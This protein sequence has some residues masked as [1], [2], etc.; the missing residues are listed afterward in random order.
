M[1]P[2]CFHRH[3]GNVPRQLWPHT[4]NPLLGPN[5]R[6]CFPGPGLFGPKLTP[7]GSKRNKRTPTPVTQITPVSPTTITYTNIIHALKE[8]ALLI[9]MQGD[10]DKKPAAKPPDEEALDAESVPAQ[11][12]ESTEAGLWEAA[13]EAKAPDLP[14]PSP[15]HVPSSP[16]AATKP[17]E[18]KRKPKDMPRRPLSAYNFFFKEERE[19][20]M[21]ERSAGVGSLAEAEQASDAEGK[22]KNTRKKELF[23]SVGKLI[24]ERWKTVAPSALERYREMA[25]EDMGRYNR[26]MSQ[27]QILMARRKRTREEQQG[28]ME[29]AKVPGGTT[30]LR[31]D[32]AVTH[33]ERLDAGHSFQVPLSFRS[34]TSSSVRAGI[35]PLRSPL[36]TSGS[37]P[38][39][40][41]LRLPSPIEEMLQARRQTIFCGG[42]HGTPPLPPGPVSMRSFEDESTLLRAALMRQAFGGSAAAAAVA[43]AGVE[44]R[45]TDHRSNVDLDVWLTSSQD[46][47]SR[48]TLSQASAPGGGGAA[49]PAAASLDQLQQH[50][51]QLLQ[52][53][54]Q[55]R[56]HH[57]SVSLGMTAA[58]QLPPP[59]PTLSSSD[60]WAFAVRP[61]LSPL[62]SLSAALAQPSSLALDAPQLSHQAPS[63]WSHGRTAAGLGNS[64]PPVSPALTT[65]TSALSAPHNRIRLAQQVQQRQLQDEALSLLLQHQH[66]QQQQQQQEQQQQQLL[67]LQ[68]LQQQSEGLWLGSK[69]SSG[70]SRGVGRS[71]AA[72]AL[73]QY[74][75]LLDWE[76]MRQSQQQQPGAARHRAREEDEPSAGEGGEGWW[77]KQQQPPPS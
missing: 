10:D 33:L 72:E 50:E 43:A 29:E 39:D 34:A 18:I 48:F 63:G 5:Q 64:S 15:P 76:R 55:D 22:D 19:R 45:P 11:T 57:S 36:A 66:Q 53:L 35:D 27:Y 9:M 71:S 13:V 47:Q 6:I 14:P 12:K 25:N 40:P 23:A 37:T 26:E 56:Q 20:L 16:S 31:L 77:W 62:D 3:K 73:Q 44:P 1:I 51:L 32:P 65:M 69:H 75:Q 46:A 41:A 58:G 68:Q 74:Q 70:G 17:R 60:A 38:I 52:L 59:T 8:E 28:M 67:L 4:A 49:A 24:A 42:A 54:E 7:A 30:R 21:A 61:P 2:K